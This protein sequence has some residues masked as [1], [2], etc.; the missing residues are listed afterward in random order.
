[1]LSLAGEPDSPI[2]P[3]GSDI[4]A[5]AALVEADGVDRALICLSSVFGIEG[6]PSAEAAPLLD[7]YAEGVA[8]L[9]DA[10]GS[11]AAVGV[12]EPDPAELDA[13]LDAGQCGLAV[14]AGAVA[15][16]AGLEHCA[17][18][19]ARLEA[20]DKP[21]L[22]HPGPGPATTPYPGNPTGGP[23]SPATWPT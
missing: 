11:W 6:L 2:D 13:R 21:L 15:G 12:A 18:L 8:T 17:P 16:A 1:M 3:A 23:R 7:A 19:L 22:V 9:P 10:F 5:R 4:A 14:P 20:R